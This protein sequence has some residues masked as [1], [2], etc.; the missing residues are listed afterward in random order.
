MGH[1]VV[2]A[3]Y[4]RHAEEMEKL[5]ANPAQYLCPTRLWQQLPILRDTLDAF[6]TPRSSGQTEILRLL[7]AAVRM[8]KWLFFKLEVA[9]CLGLTSLCWL[10]ALAIWRSPV[11]AIKYALYG[12]AGYAISKIL[13]IVKKRR[14]VDIDR[15]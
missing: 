9:K 7:Q 5:Y 2:L 12:T 13:E 11:G 6:G 15:A 3:Q 14:Y 4:S 1:G 8:N 10:V